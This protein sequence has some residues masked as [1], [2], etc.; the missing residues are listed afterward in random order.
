MKLVK[1]LIIL[2]IAA[3]L[4]GCG[5]DDSSNSNSGNNGDINTGGDGGGNQNGAFGITPWDLTKIKLELQKVAITDG[6]TADICGSGDNITVETSH[7]V[8]SFH[9]DLPTN[10]IDN[11]KDATRMTEVALAELIE[12]TGLSLTEDLDISQ[13][14]TVCYD[15]SQTGQGTAYID[16]FEFSPTSVDPNSSRFTSGYDLAK[17]EL[18]HTFKMQLIDELAFLRM[19][20]WFTESTAE[21]F[22]G[23]T[24]GNLTTT[25]LNDFVDTTKESPFNVQTWYDEQEFSSIHPQY[26][27][28]YSIYLESLAY[29]GAHGLTNEGIIQLIRDSKNS[30]NSNEDFSSFDKALSVLENSM[31][32]PS[33]YTE[34]RVP[35]TYKHQIGE[36]ADATTYR[37]DFTPKA[38]YGEYIDLYIESLDGAYSNDGALVTSDQLHYEMRGVLANATYKVYANTGSASF[39]PITVV[40]ANGK[41]GHL[42]FTD[43]PEFN[44]D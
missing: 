41:L 2:S 38:G 4:A 24:F 36:W 20:R 7:F 30:S 25:T 42:D 1:S 31:T 8:A 13:K 37:Q 39:G 33:S 19:P 15:S 35:S 27:N 34:L 32:L 18:F 21:L 29:L 9:Y 28:P 6:K 16:K 44:M 26:T 17:H 22:T 23:A 40:V 43:A 14:W 5:G 11:L 3:A 12:H 10:N